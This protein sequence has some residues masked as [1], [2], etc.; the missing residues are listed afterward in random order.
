MRWRR[1][2]LSAKGAEAINAV[3][4]P[5]FVLLLLNGVVSV[6]ALVTALIRPDWSAI[7]ATIVAWLH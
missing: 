4:K 2:S 5:L 1:F 7:S 6:L 3:R